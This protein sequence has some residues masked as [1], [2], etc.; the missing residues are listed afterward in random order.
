M[1]SVSSCFSCAERAS[2]AYVEEAVLAL[3]P[4]AT[5]PGLEGDVA[6]PSDDDVLLSP[7]ILQRAW[8][9]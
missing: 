8:N 7:D 2:G 9:I 4:D 3:Y 6:L 1:I 5:L